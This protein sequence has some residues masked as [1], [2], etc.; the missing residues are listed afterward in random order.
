MLLM[1]LLAGITLSATAVHSPKCNAFPG[2]LSVATNFT[3]ACIRFNDG[4]LAA[5]IDIN[6]GREYL[7]Y[8][9]LFQL[10]LSQG[11][12]ALPAL[13]SASFTSIRVYETAEGCVSAVF[14]NMTAFPSLVVQTAACSDPAEGVELIQWSANIT[15]VEGV[16]VQAFSFPNIA[17]P[18]R[19]SDAS[20]PSS[21][22]FLLGQSDSVLLAV[23]NTTTYSLESTYPGD[24]SVQL[25]AR[26]DDIAGLAMYTADAGANVKRFST[27]SDPTAGYCIQS[28][29]HIPPEVTGADLILSY[30]IATTTFTG[31]WR[32]AADIYK[33]WAVRQWWA[34]TLLSAREDVPPV[35]LSG[36]A[37]WTPGLPVG[38]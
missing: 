30:T 31:D 37:G 13:T 25:V 3:I 22:F 1:L 15:G 14:S 9:S 12:V 23:S 11:F 2:T 26:Y 21:D 29:T 10:V 8:T 5:F 7:S 24:V 38:G 32:D 19:F 20:S 6:S 4:S 34:G 33:A 35:L 27:Y 28:V 16:T 17:Q 36:G 18:V